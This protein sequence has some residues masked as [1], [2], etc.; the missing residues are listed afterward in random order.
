[1][2]ESSDQNESHTSNKFERN[3]GSRDRTMNA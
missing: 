1:M 3:S 2:C